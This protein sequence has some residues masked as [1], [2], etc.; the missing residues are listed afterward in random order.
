MYQI[1]YSFC[2]FDKEIQFY[3]GTGNYHTYFYYRINLLL[4]KDK[5]ENEYKKY[6]INNF[7]MITCR[8][9]DF[10]FKIHYF[11]KKKKDK[12][13][14][15]NSKKLENQDKTKIYSYICEDFVTAC[16]CISSNA[17]I[18]GLNNGKLIYYILKENKNKININKK[19]VEEKIEINIKKIKYIQSHHG[20]INTIE[21]D[22]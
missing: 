13:E 9:T 22:K 12:N 14:K 20:K 11:E 7:K 10:S 8:H 1:K 18:I 21:I 5:I 6:E 15:K 3:N 19:K 16:C 4:N 17:F 2:S